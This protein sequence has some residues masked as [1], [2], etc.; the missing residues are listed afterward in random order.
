[1]EL[2]VEILVRVGREG[3]AFAIGRDAW[4][5]LRELGVGEFFDTTAGCGDAKEVAAF[6]AAVIGSKDQPLAVGRLAE[7]R[8]VF[9][10]VAQL[11][12]PAPCRRDG[13]QLRRAGDIAE[14]SDGLPVRRKPALADVA[15]QRV[16][17]RRVRVRLDRK[18]GCHR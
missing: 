3:E 18:T 2:K 12:R 10:K 4:L 13:P 5:T 8:D 17:F 7:I 14:E 16:L 1:M 9:V 15:N 6:V 11:R